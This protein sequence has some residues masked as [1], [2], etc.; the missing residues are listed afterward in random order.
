LISEVE[1]SDEDEDGDDDDDDDDDSDG[2]K[3]R[4]GRSFDKGVPYEL[5]VDEAKW[6]I[7]PD[8]DGVSLA[9]LKDIVRSFLT[10]TYREYLI[11]VLRSYSYSSRPNYEQLQ[12]FRSLDGHHQKSCR[13]Y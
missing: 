1:N 7:L 10:L 5:K 8:T 2:K 3:R 11:L 13:I 6:P 4:R 12:D 9:I